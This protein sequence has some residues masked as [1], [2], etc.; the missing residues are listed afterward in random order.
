L[1]LTSQTGDILPETQFECAGQIFAYATFPDSYSGHHTIHG[2][3]IRPDET[4]QE[5]ILLAVN[6]DEIPDRRLFFWIQFN[7]ASW[8]K[9]VNP[10]GDGE[11]GETNEFD[12]EW[13]FQVSQGE[14]ILQ[15]VP[16]HVVCF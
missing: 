15:E 9:T 11:S 13:R 7:E 14:T 2:R 4:V 10:F 5:E 6:F 16:F 8:A 1:V 12:G 3:W